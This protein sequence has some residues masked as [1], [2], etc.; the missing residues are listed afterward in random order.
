MLDIHKDQKIY[1]ER[2]ALAVPERKGHRGR[3]PKRLKATTDELTVSEYLHTPKDEDWQRISVR[4]TAKGALV[5]GYHF[6]KLWVINPSKMQ[7]E[8]RL[9]VIRK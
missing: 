9:L 7:V 6:V 8:R 5:A 4:N 2:P 1:L 3:N